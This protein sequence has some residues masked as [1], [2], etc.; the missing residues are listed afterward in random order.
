MFNAD[1]FWMIDAKAAEHLGSSCNVSAQLNTKE[2]EK[3][4]PCL[5]MISLVQSRKFFR[6]RRSLC[7]SI[8]YRIYVY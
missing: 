6:P 5:S 7:P 3:E 1:K 4:I 8:P 2:Y